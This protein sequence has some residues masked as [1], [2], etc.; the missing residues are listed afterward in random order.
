MRRVFG[1]A[2]FT[3]GI[4]LIVLAPLLRWY[5]FPRVAK[6][7]TDVYNTSV[8][9]GQGSYF[10]AASLSQ[11]GP[12]LIRNIQTAKGDP[13][14]SNHEIAVI[15]LFSRTLDASKNSDISYSLDVYAFDRKSGYAVHCCGEA[16]RHDGV[17]LKFPFDTRQDVV[18]A[19]WDGTAKKAVPAKYVRTET[20]EGL[21]CFVFESDVPDTI[22]GTLTLP[23]F[24]VG[25]PDVA[26]V[27]TFQHYQAATTLWVEPFTGAIVR[28]GSHL[29]Q[30]AALGGKRL[31]DLADFDL[32]NT[33]DTVKATAEEISTKYAQLQLVYNW[34]PLYGP[35]TGVILVVVG[36]LL[37]FRRRVRTTGQSTGSVTTVEAPA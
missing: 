29:T 18:Y 25:Q 13:Q 35:I 9:E 6:A 20:V 7:P 10:S 8:S 12:T 36:L 28:G 24:L 30:W 14:A 19:F 21:K 37:L 3:T 16:P 33:P 2:A 23:G 26:N 27:V 15:S 32:L 5:S 31:L 4:V 34:L 22:I 17:T 11:V 1:Y